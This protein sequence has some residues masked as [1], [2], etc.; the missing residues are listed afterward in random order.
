MLT[1]IDSILTIINS[2]LTVGQPPSR[3]KSYASKFG[4]DLPAI[5]A[6][7]ISTAMGSCRSLR[8]KTTWRFAA[9]RRVLEAVT[10]LYGF[11]WKCW[12]YSQWNSHLI[13]IMISKTIG[14][15]GTLFSD[16]P[17]PIGSMVL[18]Y[19]IIYGNMNPTNIPQMLAYMPYMDPMGYWQS[20]SS[21]W[22][23]FLEIGS[24]VV[25]KRGNYP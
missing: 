1:I 23:G 25:T 21:Y 13:G 10:C 11:V 16:T 8:W 24:P 3:C 15:R 18:L 14:F 12:V 9:A 22:S 7:Q 17:I 2:I 6:S 19:M 5:F 4:M 20:G